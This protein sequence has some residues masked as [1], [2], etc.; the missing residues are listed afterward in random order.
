VLPQLKEWFGSDVPVLDFGYIASEITATDLVDATNNGSKLAVLSAFYEFSKFE[1]GD[2]PS[3]FYMAHQLQSG[4]RYYIYVTTYSGLY[5]YNMNDVIEVIDFYYQVPVIRF[6][7]KGDGITSL[8][9]E[10]LSEKQFINSVTQTAEKSGVKIGFFAGYADKKNDRY[11]LYIEFKDDLS[12]TDM[13]KFAEVTD[14][15]LQQN[16]IEYESKRKSER[17]NSPVVIPLVNDAFD[18]FR[19]LR[20]EEG[21][22]EGQFKW[23]QLF[24][25][26]L[27][28]DKIEKLAKLAWPV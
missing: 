14:L 3:E 26:D 11:T 20:L 18:M 8:Q 27:I 12:R 15:M 23:I 9:G 13:D 17:L 16:N 25:D 28:K 24:S 21:A 22:F 5:R 19:N 1:E 6:L 2:E 10:K 7:F 4:K